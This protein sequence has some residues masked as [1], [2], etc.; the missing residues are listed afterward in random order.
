[1]NSTTRTAQLIF[2]GSCLVEWPFKL[3]LSGRSV[4][5]LSLFRLHKLGSLKAPFSNPGFKPGPC[6]IA[7][8]SFENA[9]FAKF[10]RDLAVIW[11]RRF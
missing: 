4:S 3:I 7:R 10:G 2:A 1:M 9:R 8:S 11:Q 5:T 6:K